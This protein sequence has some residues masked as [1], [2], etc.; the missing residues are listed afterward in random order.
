MKHILILFSI[1]FS[2]MAWLPILRPALFA[3]DDLPWFL[4][5]MWLA[6][7]FLLAGGVETRAVDPRNRR[8]P[9]LGI[10]LQ[11]FKN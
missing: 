4:G 6:A 8:L 10:R 7:F 2:L 3:P 11:S 5:S 9:R 1:A